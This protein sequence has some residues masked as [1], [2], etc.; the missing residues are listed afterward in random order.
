MITVIREIRN[1]GSHQDF[2]SNSPMHPI[3]PVITAMANTIYNHIG[4]VSYIG[5]MASGNDDR[6]A[7]LV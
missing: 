1:I 7:G 2:R 6:E 5:C 4:W 3:R